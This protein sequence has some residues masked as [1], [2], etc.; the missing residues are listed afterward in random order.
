MKIEIS[1]RCGYEITYSTE[2]VKATEDAESREYARKEDGNIDFTKNPKRDVST[3]VIS[4]FARI[5]EDLIYYRDAPYDSQTLIECLFEKLPEQ[6]AAE[7]SVS[8]KK[9]YELEED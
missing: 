6:V 2:N 3:D 4:K 9:Q 1:S 5:T 7:L 8:L